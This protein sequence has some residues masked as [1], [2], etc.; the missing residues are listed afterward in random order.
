MPIHCGIVGLPNV[1]KSTLFNALTRAQIAA[2][3][4]PFCTIDP[5]VG[6]VPGAGSRDLLQLA[7][8]ARPEQASCRRPSSSS[9]SPAWSPGPRRARV[10]AT[11]FWR[12][13]AKS[14]RS[15]TWCAV[16]RATM[17]STSPAA[18]DPESGHRDRRHRA[19][20]GRSRHGREGTR[21][22]RRLPGRRSGD[23]DALRRRALFER[24]KVQ[25]DEAKPA[26]TLTLYRGRAARPARAA[27]A[28]DEAD[29]VCRQRRRARLLDNPTAHRGRA[30]RGRR[31]APWWYAVCAASRPRSPSST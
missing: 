13:F 29:H 26:R 25:L 20:A 2:E 16:S 7:A 27:A 1:G 11:S 28:D 10:S 15:P 24:V 22:T 17:W 21:S 12:T 8:I 19:R 4:Y 9:T 18:I 6:V 30:A 14:T 23:K 3:N 5:N 31:K